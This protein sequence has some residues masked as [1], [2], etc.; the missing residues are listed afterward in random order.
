MGKWKI[1]ILSTKADH[2]RWKS[3]EK[4]NQTILNCLLEKNLF[5]FQSFFFQCLYVDVTFMS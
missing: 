5:I 3:A 4:K 1:Q 2:D